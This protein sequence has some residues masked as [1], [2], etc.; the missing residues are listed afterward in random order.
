MS[1]KVKH[2]MTSYMILNCPK[3]WILKIKHEMISHMFLNDMYYTICYSKFDIYLVT[4]ILLEK[5]LLRLIN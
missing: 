4:L 5:Q 3:K 1:L 2:W